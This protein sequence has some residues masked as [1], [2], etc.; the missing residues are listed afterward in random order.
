MRFRKIEARELAVMLPGSGVI[1]PSGVNLSD[2]ISQR[3]SSSARGYTSAEAVQFTLNTLKPGTATPDIPGVL[4]ACADAQIGPS[5]V[6]CIP[7]YVIDLK[8]GRRI[9]QVP[10]HR[11]FCVAGFALADADVFTPQRVGS[12]AR[13]TDPPWQH[14]QSV[15]VRIVDQCHKAL[16][17]RNLAGH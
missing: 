3:N 9:G 8:A 15:V 17:Q 11:D 4:R 16:C 12:A 14:V 1:S 2:V 13:D 10:M 6:Q 5:V 7:V